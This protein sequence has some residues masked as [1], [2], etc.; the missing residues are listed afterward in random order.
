MTQGQGLE[1]E[2]AAEIILT[3]IHT[4]DQVLM[5]HTMPSFAVDSR[6]VGS[7]HSREKSLFVEIL[8]DVLRSFVDIQVETYSVSGPMTEITLR[9]PQRGP[10]KGIQLTTRSPFRKYCLCQGDVALEHQGIVFLLKRGTGT[11]GN[12]TGY[13]GGTKQV[14]SAGIA[15]V[16]AVGE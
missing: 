16:E 2:P 13:V 3:C 10:C 11:E 12:R 5:A 14:L 9:I 15:E 1:T 4:E 7:D 6:L 8:P